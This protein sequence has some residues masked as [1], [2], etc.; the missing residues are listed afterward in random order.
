MLIR[1]LFGQPLN[2][3]PPDRALEILKSVNST[4]LT[5]PHR[6][7]NDHGMAG[8]LV[9]FS[10]KSTPVIVGDLHAQIDNLLIILSK[11]CLLDCL[12][13]KTATLIILGDAVH[14][15]ISNEMEDSTS[16]VLM[17]DLLFQLKLQFEGGVFVFEV[18]FI[19]TS[20]NFYLTMSECEKFFC[21]FKVG[22]ALQ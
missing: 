16:S 22:Q 21:A 8:G 14:S 4:L 11:S 17:M 2:I 18:L 19:V 15:E 9:E 3:L 1:F 12:R 7:L 13:L 20:N 5:E 6:P 10:K